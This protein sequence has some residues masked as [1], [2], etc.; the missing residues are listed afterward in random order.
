MKTEAKLYLQAT[1]KVLIGAAAGSIA[2]RSED[3]GV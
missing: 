2:C 3:T 1:I